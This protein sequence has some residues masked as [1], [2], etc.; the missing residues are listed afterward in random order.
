MQSKTD[1]PLTAA[2][3]ARLK[4]SSC[5]K[6]QRQAQATM[7]R[8]HYATEA[9]DSG[10]RSNWGPMA[11][12]AAQGL[13]TASGRPS[14]EGAITDRR[15][16]FGWRDG[17]RMGEHRRVNATL[18]RI[19]DCEGLTAAQIRDVLFATYRADPRPWHPQVRRAIA[20]HLGDEIG[21]ALLTK[22]VQDG[23]AAGEIGELPAA[24][25]RK[26]GERSS[27]ILV[28]LPSAAAL[29][30]PATLDEVVA[31]A[32]DLVRIAHEAFLE[33]LGGAAPKRSAR[34]SE[35]PQAYILREGVRVEVKQ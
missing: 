16:G 10:L 19:Q 1:R 12:M 5:G 29:D 26:R 33:A 7:L 3:R 22:R 27:D 34:V 2:A 35:T 30:N 17:G 32:L 28:W 25:R 6:E 18:E 4:R 9:S 23:I 31:Q 24:Q 13:P 15:H 21:A 8:Q 14:Y 11:D 20:E